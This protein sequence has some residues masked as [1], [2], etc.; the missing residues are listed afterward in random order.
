ML[1]LFLKNG[2]NPN[3]DIR[4][5]WTA[6]HSAASS[7]NLEVIKML[8]DKGGDVNIKTK[9]GETPLDIA[10]KN[11]WENRYREMID[12]LKTIQKPTLSTAVK[13]NNLA[14][15]KELLKDKENLKKINDFG[16]N[17]HFDGG[18][19]GMTLLDHAAK[20]GYADICRELIKAGANVVIKDERMK[21]ESSPIVQA[22]GGGYPDAV[23]AFLEVKDRIPQQYLARALTAAVLSSREPGTK[24]VETVK[25]L[26]D[27]GVNPEWSIDDADKDDTSYNEALRY[28]TKEVVDLFLAKGLKMPFWAACK[29]GD[30][31]RMKELISKGEDINKEGFFNEFPICYAIES[32]Q[33]NAVKLLLENKCKIN[34]EMSSGSSFKPPIYMAAEKGYMKIVELLLNAGSNPNYGEQDDMMNNSP[35][36]IALQ[37]EHYDT[38]EALLKGGARTDVYDI[39]G[40]RDETGKYKEFNLTIFD[41]FKEK[42]NQEALK[43]LNKY[44]K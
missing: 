35:L 22:A 27:A 31:A 8:I 38:A 19:D 9:K 6:M 10:I 21:V 25:L 39:S 3:Y 41:Y 33:I 29:W 11:N 44:K 42:N 34:F 36:F 23:K 32:N 7:K 13:T 14:A 24:T 15:L 4:D 2:A 16:K 12:F 26:L 17:D 28:G 20:L 37:N 43:L 40:E 18:S 1:N 30:I 5:G